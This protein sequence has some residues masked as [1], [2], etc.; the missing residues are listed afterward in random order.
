[1]KIQE[2]KGLGPK[3]EEQLR[4]VGIHTPEDLAQLGAVGAF[5]KLKA[6]KGAAPSLNFLYAMVG[7]LENKHWTDISKTDKAHLLM[8]IEDHQALEAVMKSE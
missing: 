1:L 8:E 5:M 4:A 3:S 6:Q 7:A 2:L